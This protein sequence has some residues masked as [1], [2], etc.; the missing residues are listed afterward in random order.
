MNNVFDTILYRRSVRKYKNEDVKE[1]DILKIIDAA[2]LAPSG[3]NTQPWR[4][5]VIRDEETKKK[6]VEVDHNQ[7]W[8]LEA[9]VF[10]VCM[11]DISS[12]IETHCQK[13]MEE[14]C[15]IPEL[16]LVIRDTSIAITCMIL[17]CEELELSSCWTGW[18]N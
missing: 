2:R 3:S 17:E 7:K 18:F 1:C 8:M 11:A 6:I 10:I 9:P 13:I 12:R 4:F 5:L 15:E 14:D 16:K